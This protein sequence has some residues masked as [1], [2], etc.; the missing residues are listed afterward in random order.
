MAANIDL[1]SSP[2]PRSPLL[3]LGDAALPRSGSLL[4]GAAEVATKA[5]AV[6]PPPAAPDRFSLSPEARQR[7]A[8]DVLDARGAGA[9]GLPTRAPGLLSDALPTSPAATL[10]ASARVLAP[11]LPATGVP[12]PVRQLVQQLVNQLTAPV[13]PLRVLSLQP[14]TPALVRSLDAVTAADSASSPA[15]PPAD[16]GLPVLQTWLVQQG[17]VHTPDGP[18]GFALTLRLPLAWVQAQSPV[19]PPGLPAP[20]AAAP[21][22]LVFA[23]RAQALPSMPLALVVQNAAAEGPAARTNAL[24]LLEF[25]PLAQAA[26]YGREVATPRLDPW[27]QMALLQASGQLAVEEEH[28]RRRAQALCDT[29]G[30]PY[31]GR[32]TCVQPF[33]SAMRTVLPV[34]PVMDSGEGE[35]A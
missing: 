14:W 11:T 31:L 12:A 33:C 10:A 19:V 9:P 2:A 35:A 22:P 6:A 29:P 7:L 20:L 1:P 34:V 16:E 32:A 8:A 4:E 15:A 28:A 30:C 23:D 17:V 3:A 25:P 21:A 18:R 27:V 13:L 26:V 5:A 24:L